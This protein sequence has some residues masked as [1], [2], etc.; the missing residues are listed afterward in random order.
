MILQTYGVLDTRDRAEWR[1]DHTAAQLVRIVSVTRSVNKPPRRM[2]W[3]SIRTV[4][5]LIVHWSVS[6]CG[7]WRPAGPGRVTHKV[8]TSCGVARASKLTPT[9]LSPCLEFVRPRLHRTEKSPGQTGS[10][11]LCGQGVVLRGTG[12]CTLTPGHGAWRHCVLMVVPSFDRGPRGCQL[13]VCLQMSPND[14]LNSTSGRQNYR[15]K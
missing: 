13:N 11:K 9:S 3:N 6:M 5:A 4:T 1:H 15:L 10:P 12:R 8:N 14:R 2:C 7:L